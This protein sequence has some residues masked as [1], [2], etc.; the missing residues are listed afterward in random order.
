MSDSSSNNNTSANLASAPGDR[1][2][3][4]AHVQH[5][6]HHGGGWDAAWEQSVT[7][8]RLGQSAP[9]LQDLVKNNKFPLPATGRVLV[10]GCGD[11]HD[12]LF[13]GT[14]ERPALGLDI[15]PLAV[16]EA[17]KVRDALGVSAEVASYTAADFF[18]LEGEF[19]II[20]DYTF[21]CAI[22]PDMRAGWSSQMGKLIQKDGVL[23]T[24]MYP[25]NEER[26]GGP[27]FVLSKELYHELLDANFDLVYFD[28][29]V[30]SEQAR[31]GREAIGVWRRK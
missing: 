24:L 30:Q 8:W 23:V 16:Q 27:P 29:N 26:E 12:V 25:L 7:P 18:T 3:P 6:I 31:Q 1:P 9:A 20:Y 13:L 11:G 19:T 17:N 14:P 5:I 10:P 15:S 28:S 2:T 4:M 22:N 21:L